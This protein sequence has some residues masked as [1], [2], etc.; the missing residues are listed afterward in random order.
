MNPYAPLYSDPVDLAFVSVSVAA[1]L[2]LAAGVLRR[3][4]VAAPT[5]SEQGCSAA[6]LAFLSLVV[7]IMALFAVGLVFLA[8]L[9]ITSVFWVFWQLL[10][11]LSVV[12][13]FWVL[14]FVAV[15]LTC[16]AL[17]GRWRLGF[18]PRC[19]KLASVCLPALLLDAALYF[20]LCYACAK[21]AG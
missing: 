6:A 4:F 3:R 18:S 20:W 19:L 8:W 5:R 16:W 7:A 12:C 13:V 17:I 10:Y 1:W 11:L 9:R 21:D 14:P 15:G 2:I